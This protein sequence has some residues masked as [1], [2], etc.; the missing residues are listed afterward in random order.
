MSAKGQKRTSSASFDY[1]VG[2]GKQRWR[3]G[4]A[5]GLGSL[6]VDDRLELGRRLH[7]QIS[8]LFP[9]ED[10]IDVPRRTA[11]IVHQ[12]SPKGDQAAVNHQVTATI[13]RGQF[14]LGRKSDNEIAMSR[15]RR[16]PGHN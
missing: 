9:L 2:A 1:L 12:I 13:D 15:R 7:W 6:Q 14:V 11:V 5:E 16:A 8:R 4:E 10:A 3:H